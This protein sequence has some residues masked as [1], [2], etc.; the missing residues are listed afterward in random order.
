V[1]CLS[2]TPSATVGCRDLRAG[3]TYLQA[4]CQRAKS[5]T[6]LGA[7]ILGRGVLEEEIARVIAQMGGE[8]VR[9]YQTLALL[10]KKS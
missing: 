7:T 4:I 8:V 6:C 10:A 3:V 9:V 1:P 5:P 2:P